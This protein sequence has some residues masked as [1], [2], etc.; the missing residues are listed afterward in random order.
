VFSG[1][2]FK[3]AMVSLNESTASYLK[4]RSYFCSWF[5]ID[6]SIATVLLWKCFSMLSLW[7]TRKF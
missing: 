2:A 1:F 3:D 5:A 4:P 6:S 7:L